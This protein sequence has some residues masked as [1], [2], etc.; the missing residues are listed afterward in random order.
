MSAVLTILVWVLLGVL[1]LILLASV[2][3]LRIELALRKREIWLYSAVLRPFA[4]YGPRFV[5]ADSKTGS[6]IKQH[7]AKE[8]NRKS[9]SKS[10]RQRNTAHSDPLLFLQA[11]VDLLTRL[12]RL[13]RVDS[14]KVDVTLGLGDPA[15][16]GQAFG[17]LAPFVYGSCA[18]RRVQVQVEPVFN[19]AVFRG[20]A[21]LSIS[22]IPVFLLPPLV[23]FGWSVLGPK[24]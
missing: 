5:V 13:V 11:A 18:M 15:D 20:R 1:A 14:A 22:L 19:R 6:K 16:T 7:E 21:E 9:D 10:R 4:G 12:W 23:V 17:L 3:P 2:L 24:S 8:K